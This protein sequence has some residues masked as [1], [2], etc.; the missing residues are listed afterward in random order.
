MAICGMACRLP[1]GINTPQELWEFVVNK[2]DA[3]K[4][5]PLSRYDADT[6]LGDGKKPGTVPTAYGYFLEN[7][8]SA[9]DSSFFSMPAKELEHCDPQQRL[10]LEVTREALEDAGETAWRG[11]SIGVY[12]GNFAEDWLN[13]V[14]R[15]SM[16][17]NMYNI[18]GSVDF[19][20]SN[21]IS[22][23]MDLQGPR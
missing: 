10:L 18:F 13:I 8:L 17:Y 5:I 19:N 16:D 15:D 12:V 1:G 20:L 3:R 22:Y 14:E 7:D 2:G 6:Y 4:R 23:E 11:R 9:I 21:R